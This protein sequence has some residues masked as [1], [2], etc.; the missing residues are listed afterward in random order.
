MQ[1]NTLSLTDFKVDYKPS[2]L[3]LQHADELAANI[4]LYASQVDVR[5]ISSRA[6]HT[7]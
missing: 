7:S 3:T 1:N 5:S 2:V 6:S 4:K